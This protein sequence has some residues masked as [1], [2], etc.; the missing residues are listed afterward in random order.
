LEIDGDAMIGFEYRRLLMIYLV[1]FM[2][3]LVV[4]ILI[5]A[6]P[7]LL[8]TIEYI[9]LRPVKYGRNGRGFEPLPSKSDDRSEIRKE[10]HRM[11]AILE[12]DSRG[13]QRDPYA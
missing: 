11:T 1:K 13:I 9:F 3:F 12:A 4:A 5:A 10:I 8:R 6:S 7:L 2:A